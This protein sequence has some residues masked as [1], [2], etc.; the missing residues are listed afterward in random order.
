MI[1]VEALY[2]E[3]NAAHFKNSLPADLPIEWNYSLRTTAGRCHYRGIGYRVSPTK[4]DLNPRLLDS[5]EKI[6]NTL[7]H[8]M[9]H[10]WLM[11]DTGE[12]HGH[13]VFFQ[14]KMDEIVGYK[15]SH[16]YHQYDVSDLQEV[17]GIEYHCPKHGVV[18]HRAR[19]PR[20]Y[21]LNRYVCDYCG[22]RIEFVD[23]R[24][25]TSAAA[26]RKQKSGK[27]SI[28]IRLK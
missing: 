8:E 7:T 19:M 17:R 11:L 10:A 24:P 6:R 26:S 18:G 23:T 14:R 28:K 2:L 4:I 20:A 21:D 13:D 12:Y 5:D 25:P 22:S 3:I 1:D 9:V 15:C 16:T 27:L